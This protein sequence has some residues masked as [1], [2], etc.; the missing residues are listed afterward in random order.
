MKRDISLYLKDVFE[1]MKH[2]E[3][4]IENLTYEKTG[5]KKGKRLK[6]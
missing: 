2:L 3:V 4:F 1:N 6:K 5:S